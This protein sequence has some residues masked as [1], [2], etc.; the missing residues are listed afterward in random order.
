VL[1]RRAAEVVVNYAWLYDTHSF[2]ETYGFHW[3]LFD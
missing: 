2:Q 1:G 3:K